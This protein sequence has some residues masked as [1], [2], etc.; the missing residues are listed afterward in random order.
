MVLGF[1]D[2][3]FVVLLVEGVL[4]RQPSAAMRLSLKTSPIV[5][6]SHLVPIG[7]GWSERTKKKGRRVK[8]TLDLLRS[9]G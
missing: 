1:G 9:V 8:G 5:F 7:S 4:H 6:G 2:F 3:A